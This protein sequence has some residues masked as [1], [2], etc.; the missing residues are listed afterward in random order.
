[1]FFVSSNF[2][3]PYLSTDKF[4]QILYPNGDRFYT[5]NVI[6]NKKVS[7]N[8]KQ[9]EVYQEGT[10]VKVITFE[11][12]AEA[13]NGFRLLS[14]AIDALRPNTAAFNSEFL[15]TPIIAI[16]KKELGNDLFDSAVVIA[17]IYS[18]GEP[19]FADGVEIQ[20]GDTYI[21][22][23]CIVSEGTGYLG[24]GNHEIWT[25]PNFLDSGFEFQ[26]ESGLHYYLDGEEL[27]TFDDLVICSRNLEGDLIFEQVKVSDN[28]NG[29]IPKV[30]PRCLDGNIRASLDNYGPRNK[31][32]YQINNTLYPEEYYKEKFDIYFNSYG[33]RPWLKYP[34]KR[35]ELIIVKNKSKK[36]P[37]GPGSLEGT[38]KD[39]ATNSLVHPS[40]ARATNINNPNGIF[41]GGDGGRIRDLGPIENITDDYFLYPT[42]F[43]IDKNSDSFGWEGFRKRNK[44]N[45]PNITITLDIRKYFRDMSLETLMAPPTF[46]YPVVMF[47]S[48]TGNKP[49]KIRVRNNGDIKYN[50]S[51]GKAYR[52]NLI[53]Y[54]RLS[55]GDPNSLDTLGK[56]ARYVFILRKSQLGDS[57]DVDFG[58]GKTGSY[59]N[60]GD[61]S[62]DLANLFQSL[63]DDYN[64]EISIEPDP[65][66]PDG[67]MQ[68]LFRYKA[69]KYVPDFMPIVS[70]LQGAEIE[71][72]IRKKTNSQ[73]PNTLY[74]KRIYSDLSL[75]IYICPRIDIFFDDYNAPVENQCIIY[76]HRVTIGQKS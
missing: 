15:P 60:T 68:Y 55:A 57:F 62:L 67:E 9:V 42:E 20:N 10:S 25:F 64:I 74:K 58:N 24:G 11:N 45:N 4:L 22:R 40:N 65:Q 35:V 31:T 53:L 37:N 17:R 54:F 19:L 49:T 32:F 44:L 36:S 3:K 71:T 18:G 5:L 21:R 38:L 2:I 51:R 28:S 63:V 66:G 13:R 7:L 72:V 48:A 46:K 50:S 69:K 6:Q 33:D 26:I 47:D 41:S 34:D 61:A 1:M 56:A 29:I 8:K 76:G 59:I 39:S 43:T 73:L 75:P 16:R 23:S 27:K 52:R 70:N 30:F 14:N 12:E